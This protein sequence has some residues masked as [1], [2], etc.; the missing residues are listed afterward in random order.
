M[1]ITRRWLLVAIAQGTGL[2]AATLLGRHAPDALATRLRAL[3]SNPAGARRIGALYLQQ[4]SAE[5]DATYL[6]G[7]ILSSLQLTRAQALKLRR[8]DLSRCF[9]VAVRGDFAAGHTVWVEG[10][11]L[12]R[13][14]ARAC[15]LWT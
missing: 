12:S 1:A 14:E 6:S 7:Q 3:L 5:I 13:T 15:A 10:W 8:R 4:A 2:L 9:S 11:L